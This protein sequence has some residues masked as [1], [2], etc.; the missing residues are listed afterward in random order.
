MNLSLQFKVD[1]LF[2]F[3]FISAGTISIRG[4][5]LFYMRVL[6]RVTHYTSHA[7]ATSFIRTFIIPVSFSH[8][9]KYL[10]TVHLHDSKKVN[11]IYRVLKAPFVVKIFTCYLQ[12]NFQTFTCYL[13]NKYC[14]SN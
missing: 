3:Y 14:K 13:Q 8:L 6:T 12:D 1:L 10:F 9:H 2:L 4:S 5:A 7:C 11:L